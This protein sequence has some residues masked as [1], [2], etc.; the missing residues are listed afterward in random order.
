M[1][2]VVDREGVLP[3]HENSLHGDQAFGGS[4]GF[5]ISIVTRNLL[6]ERFWKERMGISTDTWVI[7]GHTHVPGIDRTVKVA[8]T[9]GWVETPLGT[10]IGRGISVNEQGEVDLVTFHS[11]NQ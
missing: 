3:L 11:Y 5:A 10:P 6:L 7:M 8:N 1:S 2:C 4:F 9:G